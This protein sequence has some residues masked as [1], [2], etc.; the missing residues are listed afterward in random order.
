MARNCLSVCAK[1]IPALA[2]CHRF[3]DLGTYNWH[4]VGESQTKKSIKLQAMCGSINTSSK[5]RRSPLYTGGTLSSSFHLTEL[6]MIC[7]E[8]LLFCLTQIYFQ[9]T[10]F[11][12][13]GETRDSKSASWGA[14]M[15]LFTSKSDTAPLTKSLASQFEGKIAFGESRA[16]NKVLGDQ[17]GV[18]RWWSLLVLILWPVNSLISTF[19][20]ISNL[21]FKSQSRNTCI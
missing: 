5:N 21:K 15:I 17:F 13:L 9:V 12:K 14:N 7:N 19:F 2:R 1:P 10:D 3:F 4:S 11:L 20:L 8:H 18:S 6:C 16:S